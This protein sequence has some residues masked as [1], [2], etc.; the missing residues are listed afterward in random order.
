MFRLSFGEFTLQPIYVVGIHRLDSRLNRHH[1]IERCTIKK[2]EK[3]WLGSGFDKKVF[4]VKSSFETI[5]WSRNSLCFSTICCSFSFQ[6]FL[7]DRIAYF[8]CDS[9]LSS[10]LWHIGLKDSH[11]YSAQIFFLVAKEFLLVFCIGWFL[12]LCWLHLNFECNLSDFWK[13]LGVF[14]E[15]KWR[16]GYWVQERSGQAQRGSLGEIQG[17]L[18]WLSG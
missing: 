5:C 14:G 12:W 6:G 15:S 10:A 1:I 2:A 8:P 4:G 7:L 18:I 9:S 11:S 13:L 3:G 17:R 16:L